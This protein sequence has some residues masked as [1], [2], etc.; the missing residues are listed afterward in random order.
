VRSDDERLSNDTKVCQGVTRARGRW[1]TA[2]L[3]F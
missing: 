3:A 2:T 1:H